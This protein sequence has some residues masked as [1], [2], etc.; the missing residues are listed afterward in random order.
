MLKRTMQSVIKKI[1]KMFPAILLTGMRQ[2][3]KSTLFDLVKDSNRK[4]VSL[5]NF[6]DRELAKTNPAL[7]IERYAPPVIIDEIQYAPELFSY[8]KI[9]VDTHKKTGTFGLQ[10]LKNMS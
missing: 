6:E 5:D 7:F 1:S 8:I 10:V 9:Y 4:Y 3:G 2:I